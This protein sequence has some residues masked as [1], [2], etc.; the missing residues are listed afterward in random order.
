MNIA[1]TKNPLTVTIEHDID[2]LRPLKIIISSFWM[3]WN[4][5]VE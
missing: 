5:R 2:F 4:A 3:I 1:V